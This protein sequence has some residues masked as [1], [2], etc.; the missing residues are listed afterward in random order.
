MKCDTAEAFSIPF[1]TAKVFKCVLDYA[2]RDVTK[3]LWQRE[4]KL[5]D[6]SYNQIA[7]KGFNDLLSQKLQR[8]MTSETESGDRIHGGLQNK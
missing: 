2:V 3:Y 5:F 6:F 1:T 4:R 8:I 7:E